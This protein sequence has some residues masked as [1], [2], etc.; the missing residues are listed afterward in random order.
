MRLEFLVL[1][2]EWLQLAR[3]IHPEIRGGNILMQFAECCREERVRVR[4]GE[5]IKDD[6]A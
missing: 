3:V 6:F 1:G 5:V 4:G 2:S